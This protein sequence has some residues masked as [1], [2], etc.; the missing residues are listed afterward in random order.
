MQA[1]YAPQ[2]MD[3]WAQSKNSETEMSAEF[4]ELLKI[5]PRRRAPWDDELESKKDPAVPS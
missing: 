5:I 3:Y 1:C 4:K 2:D